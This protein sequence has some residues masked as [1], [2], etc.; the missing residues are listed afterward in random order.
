MFSN[1]AHS[2]GKT[3]IRTKT[4]GFSLLALFLIVLAACGQGGSTTSKSTS[5]SSVLTIVP[6]P[7]GDFTNGFTPLC[8]SGLYGSQG[9]IYETLLFFNRMNGDVKPWLAQSYAFSSDAKA[10]TIRLR[11]DVKWSDGPLFPSS[12][13][14]FTL[15]ELKQYPTADINGLWQYLQSVQATDSST[16]VVTLKAPYTPVLWYLAGQTYI[17]SQHEY[18][19]AGDPTKF[20]DV[21]PIG[22]GPF[23]LNS[24]SPQLIDLKKNPNYWQPGK[25]AVTEIRYPSFDSNTSAEL[26]L[27]RGSVDWTGLFTPNIQQTYVDKDPAHN[28]YWFPN[29]NIVMLY[30]NTAKAPFNQLAVRQAISNA[31]DRNQ[32]Y[33]VAESGYEPIS[34]P[35]RLVL[36]ANQ[37]NLDS[38]YV[39]AS[40]DAISFNSSFSALALGIFYM[41]I[42]W[43]KPGPTPF[44][45]YNSM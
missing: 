40:C 6:S 7:K 21:H 1:P 28:H 4:V 38:A 14:V 32:I 30:L 41:D 17:V 29:R 36:P 24:F 39:H 10:L 15:N 13:V 8:G 22:T 37:I 16:V 35:T 19:S 18:A 27:Q 25:P 26:L 45:L 31:I 3:K 20:A 33:K 44:N 5:T 12:V 9:M 2:S 42:C 11:T 34:S 43:T 23:V